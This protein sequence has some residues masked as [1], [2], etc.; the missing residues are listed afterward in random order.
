[1]KK[2]NLLL[3]GLLLMVLTV[4]AQEETTEVVE[5]ESPFSVSADIVSSYVWR[6]SKFGLGPAIQPGVE[7]SSGGLAIGGWGSVNTSMAEG[8]EMDLYI[9]YTFDFG[10]S[11]GVNDYYFPYDAGDTY[12]FFDASNHAYELTAGFES[13][14]FSLTTGYIVNEGASGEGDDVYVEAGY[15]FG[16]ANVFIGGG[17][18]W[19]STYDSFE[20]VNI[21]IGASKDIKI[22]DSFS[23]PVFGN[24][25]LNPNQEQL[26]IVFGLSL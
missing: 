10:L 5:E 2:L 12:K 23:L 14:G 13:G 19:Y 22:S 9:S 20:I 8:T 25:I 26:F 4:S 16:P 11:L 6:G 21:G 18:G 7:Y 15:D 24:V 1:M 17:N 3:A